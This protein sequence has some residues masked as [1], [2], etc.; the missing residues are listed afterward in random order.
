MRKPVFGSNMAVFF[1]FFGLAMIDAIQMHAWIRVTF[2]SVIAV[3][4][5][6]AD[7][8]RTRTRGDSA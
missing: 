8:D 5:L 2:W 3:F 1:L 7:L 6:F 4:F